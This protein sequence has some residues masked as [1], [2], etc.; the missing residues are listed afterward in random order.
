MGLI[1]RVSSRT[2]RDKKSTHESKCRRHWRARPTMVSRKPTTVKWSTTK[3]SKS[4]IPTKSNQSSRKVDTRFERIRLFLRSGRSAREKLIQHPVLQLFQR[5]YGALHLNRK[6]SLKAVTT[7][8]YSGRI[9]K[10]KVPKPS[11]FSARK[12]GSFL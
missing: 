8:F 7:A 10:S 12:T 9:P 1:S 6:T 4:T 5:V 2:Y 11:T 3:W